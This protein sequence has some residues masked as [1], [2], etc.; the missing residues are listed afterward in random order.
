[1]LVDG[2]RVCSGLLGLDT[3]IGTQ[4]LGVVSSRVIIAKTNILASRGFYFTCL[5][6]NSNYNIHELS[7]T[8][9]C[10]LLTFTVAPRP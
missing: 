4:G 9:S 2:A 3:Q 7:N 10:W 8:A 6:W 1:M 5:D